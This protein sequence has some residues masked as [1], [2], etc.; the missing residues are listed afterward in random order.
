MATLPVQRTWT[1]GLDVD[2]AMLNDDVRD[3]V[4]FFLNAPTCRVYNSAAITGIATSTR[5]ALTFNSERYDNDGIHS[6]A[7]NTSRL[8]CVT[9]G[10]YDIFGVADL[11]ANATG[12]RQIEIRLNGSTLL[13][14]AGTP[15][16]ASN[17][18]LS[19]STKYKL[20]VGDYVELT[21]FHTAGTNLDVGANGNYSPEFGCSW[22][23]AG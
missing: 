22:V 9:A 16:N 7:T 4:N 19:I 6:T 18:P 23:S 13:A 14:V 2:A 20:A 12:I 1:V 5:T 3:A 15:G 17:V 21:I 11:G 10:V 8:T